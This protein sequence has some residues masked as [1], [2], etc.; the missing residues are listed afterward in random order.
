M[1]TPRPPKAYIDFESASTVDLKKAGAFVYAAHP[2]TRILCLAYAIED[3]PVVS[4]RPGD[5][6]PIDLL[7]H[8]QKGGL[9]S[10]W[11]TGG[12]EQIIWETFCA[13]HWGV[14]PQS[15]WRCTMIKSAY[16]GLPMKLRDAAN[17]LNLPAR[18][19]DAGHRL[20][21]Q[22]SKPRKDGTWWHETDPDK[23]DRLVAYCEQDVLVERAIDR[24]V[25]E[26]PELELELWRLDLAMNA[27]G[28]PVDKP[29]LLSL[30]EFCEAE[31]ERIKGECRTAYGISP[32]Q[33]SELLI[34]VNRGL[35]GGILAPLPDV[36]SETV[37]SAIE[38]LELHGLAGCPSH[39]LLCMRR[40]FA[41]TSVKKF[42]AIE[43]AL[44]EGDRVRGMLQFY[45]ASRTGRWAGRLAQLQNLPRPMR[46]LDVKSVISDLTYGGGPLAVSLPANQS[47]WHPFVND[48]VRDFYGNPLDV[49]S[50]LIRSVFTPPAGY[51]FVV[52]DL[53]QIEARVL[54]WLAGHQE[55]LAVFA[56][57]EDLYVYAAAKVGS[58]NRQYGKVQ[59]LALG[60]GMGPGRFQETAKTYGLDLDALQS[61]KAVRDWRDVNKPITRL[62]YKCDEAARQVLGNHAIVLN[63]GSKLQFAM[64]KGRLAGCMLIRL[65]SGRL[66]CYRNARVYDPGGDNSIVYDGT[67]QKTRLWGMI[68]TYGAKLVENIVQAIARDVMA[69][70]MERLGVGHVTSVLMPVLTV[71]DELVCLAPEKDANLA[72]VGLEVIMS[73]PAPWCKGL[74]LAADVKIM[75]RYGK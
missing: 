17:A 50:S 72:K 67:D 63:V 11:N 53:A 7:N 66:L 29:L 20:M 70:A 10:G 73:D 12:F 41:K 68:R 75:D 18:K 74:P 26:L 52:G 56:R 59:E 55:K 43:K 28:V 6:D 51:K 69:M 34:Y 24:E 48:Y 2:D 3:G 32:S 35:A 9:V 47:T 33:T 44:G 42:A 15:Q 8:I 60:Y 49:Y 37:A 38:T 45:G 1:A 64:G 46:G 40:D 71:H 23:Y 30:K 65:P 36:R 58:T 61:E 39:D 31:I 57:G 13:S 16:W 21:L 5:R 25:P 4:W 19:D 27:R 62:W 22:V 54:A 14:V